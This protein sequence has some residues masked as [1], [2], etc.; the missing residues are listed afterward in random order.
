MV[1]GVILILLLV[2][3]NSCLLLK[4]DCSSSP[5]VGE[6]PYCKV[7]LIVLIFFCFVLFLVVFGHDHTMKHTKRVP[8][9]PVVCYNPIF[10]W[11][12][13]LITYDNLCYLLVQWP[14]EGS[15]S[16]EEW[17]S[18]PDRSI[19]TKPTEFSWYEASKNTMNK[20]L[21][22]ALRILGKIKSIVI[23]LLPKCC[24]LDWR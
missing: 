7:F 15:S 10:P 8:L 20:L 16:I 14:G 21:D 23:L 22:K 9:S 6:E 12:L 17:L 4:L 2:I 5:I 3:Q 19:K 1:I 18:S 11:S 24:F 13:G